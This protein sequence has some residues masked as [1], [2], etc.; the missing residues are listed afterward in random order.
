M[1]ADEDKFW[2]L[3]AECQ[4]E[5]QF[6]SEAKHKIADEMD[7]Y[8]E[9]VRDYFNKHNLFQESK[10]F[11]RPKIVSL[12]ENN[13]SL[14]ETE[15]KVFEQF[16]NAKI[17]NSYGADFITDEYIIE[18]KKTLNKYNL[19]KAYMQLKYAEEKLQSDKELLVLAESVDFPEGKVSE[20]YRYTKV[21]DMEIAT[22]DSQIQ[23]LDNR[24]DLL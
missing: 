8:H 16:E 15:K 5:N 22:F 9:T 19:P 2:Q 14:N 23:F 24:D 4:E 7:L 18:V 11:Q 17:L 3:V 12:N 10:E 6:F 21:L 13:K 1:R 20:Y